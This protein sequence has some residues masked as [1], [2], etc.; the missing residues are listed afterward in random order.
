MPR[1]RDGSFSPELWERWQRSE[2][3]FVLALLEMV[4]QG[5]S[6]RKVE[7]VCEELCGAHFSKSTVSA[8]CERLD[9]LVNHWRNRPLT[10]VSYPFLLLVHT[11]MNDVDALV[12]RVRED[13]QVRP[14]SL[15]LACGVREDGH[16]EILG[17]ALGDSES[18]ANWSELVRVLCQSEAAWTVG[19]LPGDK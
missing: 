2:Q 19:H 10:E 1:L 13:K 9:P 6:T 4:I 14:V 18:E 15:L 12:I 5:I 11:G 17:F 3:A 8:L 7:A 16:R